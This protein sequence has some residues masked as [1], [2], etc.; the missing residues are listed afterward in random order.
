MG[1]QITSVTF[2]EE[3]AINMAIDET[4]DT[5]FYRHEQDQDGRKLQEEF[6]EAN[7]RKEK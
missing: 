6:N 4:L 7:K 5:K 1:S 2:D 3:Y